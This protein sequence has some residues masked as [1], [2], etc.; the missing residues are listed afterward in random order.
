MSPVAKPT[1]AQRTLLLL[2][3]L[4]GVLLFAIGIRYLAAPEAAALTFG[5]PKRPQALELHYITGLR[6]VWLGGLAIA[7]A[8]LREWR[9][10]ALWFAMATIVCF[11]D[12]FIAAGSA[13]RWPHVAFHVASGI[14]SIGLSWLA[15]REFRRSG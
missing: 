8:A 2:C 1:R 11:A 9:A 15:F 14:A 10:L 6:N 3:L 5:I 13:G 7:F 4:G 12:A